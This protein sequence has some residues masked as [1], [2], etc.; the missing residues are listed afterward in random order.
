MR[1][2]IF[3]C[4]IL[5]FPL[6]AQELEEDL[7]KISKPT[8]WLVSDMTL[9]EMNWQHLNLEKEVSFTRPL[10][11]SWKNFLEENNKDKKFDIQLCLDECRQYLRLWEEK[12]PPV[13]TEIPT[14]AYANGIWLKLS[15]DLRKLPAAH[16]FGWE[17][18]VVA[19]DIN[20]KRVLVSSELQP[21][22]KS[23]PGLEQKALNSA[24]ATRIYRTPLS[25]LKS[26]PTELNK[27]SPL[28][29]ASKLVIKG[30]RNLSDVYKLI[31]VLKTRGSSLGI[32]F[33]WEFFGP[34]DAQVLCFYAGEEKSFTDLLSQ[35]KELKSSYNYGLVN[36]LDGTTHVLKMVP[37]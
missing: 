15:I 13:M 37:Q 31:E 22:N 29:R 26:L 5:S 28:N 1:S 4:W 10:M 36:E 18:R 21:E 6:F 2:W 19:L 33:S 23:W 27:L 20:T 8:I 25:V 7:P 24:L 30:Y 35:L 12:L 11:E 34:T 17:G 32:E 14:D 9:Y 3:I 16:S